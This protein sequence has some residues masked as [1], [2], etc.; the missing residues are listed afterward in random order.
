MKAFLIVL[1]F[2]GQTVL[3]PFEFTPRD[4]DGVEG[5]S[6]TEIVLSCSEE[7]EKV[8]EEIAEHSWDDPRGHGYFLNDG[9]GTIQGHIC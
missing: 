4:M 6:D 3:M 9:T 1:L 7:A 2:S 8:Y 5:I